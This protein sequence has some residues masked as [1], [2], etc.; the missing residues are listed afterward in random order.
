MATILIDAAFVAFIASSLL[1][2]SPFGLA[3][4]VIALVLAACALG[5]AIAEHRK[6]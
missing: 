6:P 1:Q 5:A 4:V 2:G 3:C